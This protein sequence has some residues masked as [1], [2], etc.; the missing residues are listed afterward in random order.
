MVVPRMADS[1]DQAKLKNM[2][3]LMRL[4]SIP[5]SWLVQDAARAYPKGRIGTRRG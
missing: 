4:G 1:G 2:G 3:D 5:A